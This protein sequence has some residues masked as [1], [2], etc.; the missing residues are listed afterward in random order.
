MRISLKRFESIDLHGNT[1][2][3]FYVLLKPTQKELDLFEQ[4]EDIKLVANNYL[5]ESLISSPVGTLIRLY[6][7][8]KISISSLIQGCDFQCGVVDD[9]IEVEIALKHALSIVQKHID[10]ALD[11]SEEY[12]LHSSLDYQYPRL[13]ANSFWR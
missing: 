2:Y 6:D 9:V 12:D 5:I 7:V 11:F 8:E 3:H 10:V 1:K 13:V 4:N